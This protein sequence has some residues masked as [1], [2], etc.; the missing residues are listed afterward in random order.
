MWAERGGAER[1]RE[2]A[3]SA[4]QNPLHYKTNQSKKLKIDFKS[5]HETVSINSLLL[6]LLNKSDYLAKEYHSNYATLWFGYVKCRNYEQL[7]PI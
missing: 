6:S 4:A 1:S 2:Q 7:Y 5:Y 3:K